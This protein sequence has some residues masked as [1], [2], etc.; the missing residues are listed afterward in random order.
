MFINLYWCAFLLVWMCTTGRVL[1]DHLL[2]F[3]PFSLTLAW[4]SCQTSGV[5]LPLVISTL[6]PSLH[7]LQMLQWSGAAAFN[8]TSK[9]ARGGKRG[10]WLVLAADPTGRVMWITLSSRNTDTDSWEES[11][12][13]DPTSCTTRL[14][15]WIQ[16]NAKK[17][18]FCL[19]SS[20]A[21]AVIGGWSQTE[22][23]GGILFTPEPWSSV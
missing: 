5:Q 10:W 21:A 8:Q 15:Q 4:H 12:S 7:A 16:P 9:I 6:I 18:Y 11:R 2:I 1:W 22:C 3:C 23:G 17:D 20:H 13:S 14:T 19:S